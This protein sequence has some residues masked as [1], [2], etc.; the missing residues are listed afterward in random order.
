[1]TSS[2]SHSN[3]GEFARGS[4]V[5]ERRVIDRCVRRDRLASV[6]AAHDLERRFLL[7]AG[8]RRLKGREHGRKAKRGKLAD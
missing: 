2:G 3:A 7:E 5:F 4:T 8:E 6:F 1:M